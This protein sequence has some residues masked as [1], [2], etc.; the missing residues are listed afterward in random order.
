M[1]NITMLIVQALFWILISLCC[2]FAALAGGSSGRHG[3]WLI[4]VATVAT[5]LLELSSS[6]TKTHV[7]VMM[8]DILLL[9]GLY[10]LALQSKVYWPI[11][12][13]GFHMLTVAGHIA[14]IIMPD[15]RLGIYWRFSGIWSVLVLMAMVIGISLDRHYWQLRHRA[16][17]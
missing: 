6:W 11:W 3:A 13:S 17:Q 2:S 4:L 10:H 9:I 16:V 14:T 15:F 8:I 7:P 12:A 1:S 5:W